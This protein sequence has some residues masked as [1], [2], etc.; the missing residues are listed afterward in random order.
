MASILVEGTWLEADIP[1]QT[2]L[3]AHSQEEI[4]PVVRT[5]D[6]LAS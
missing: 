4:Q 3:D 6:E 5:V 1:F 2:I